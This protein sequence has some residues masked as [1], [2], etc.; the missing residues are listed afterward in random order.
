VPTGS[1][2]ADAFEARI[3]EHDEAWLSPL[4]VRSYESRG[5]AREEGECRVR[6]P[7]QRDRDRILHSKPFRRLK[8]KT[9]VFIDPAGD[10]FRTRMT[11]TLETTGIARGVARALRLN[12]DLTEAIGLGHDMG[13]TPFGHAGEEALDACLRERFGTGFRH[14][15][16]SLRIA[17]S[18]NLTWEVRDGILTHT[19]DVDPETHEGKIVRIVDRVA[20]I[21]H[22]I[23]DAI[24][25]GILGPDDL[26]QDEVALL[27]PTGS[28]RIDTLVHDLVETSE[29]AGD[30]VQSDEIGTA[31]LSLRSFMFER[32]YLGPRTRAE[33]ARASETVRL[34]F[35]H[36]ADRG[37]PPTE[38][39]DYLSGMTDRFALEYAA[40]L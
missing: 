36:L 9:Q 21:N 13:H 4:A 29:S 38:I 14:N 8:G 40:K 34:I 39:V 5:R 19:G 35:D 37:D 22:D 10:H 27:G 1:L 11:H 26:P 7:F 18:L 16:Q 23:D 24:R 2:V 31:M 25:H 12:E 15:E 3:R 33:H 30:I 17:E 20:Y 6:T 28:K 32:V